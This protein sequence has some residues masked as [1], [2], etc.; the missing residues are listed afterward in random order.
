[1]DDLSRRW[2]QTACR[3]EMRSQQGNAFQDFYAS[4]M[5]LAHPRD[6]QRILPYG[7]QGD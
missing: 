5:E 2:D 6:F 1:M 7:N 3:L 4:V